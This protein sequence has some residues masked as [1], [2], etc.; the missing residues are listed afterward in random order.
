MKSYSCYYKS[1]V[2]PSKTIVLRF[3]AKDAEDANKQAHNFLLIDQW[4]VD[5]KE[6]GN[7]G[8]VDTE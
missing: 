8:Q 5:L 1:K 2:D 3:W 4:E 6:N 7:S